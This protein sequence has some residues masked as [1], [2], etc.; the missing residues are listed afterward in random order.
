LRQFG[1]RSAAP[2]PLRLINYRKTNVGAKIMEIRKLIYG[3][4][5]IGVAHIETDE[6]GP[7]G[8]ILTVH[9]ERR[10]RLAEFIDVVTSTTGYTPPDW[11]AFYA[12]FFNSRGWTTDDWDAAA[13]EDINDEAQDIADEIEIQLIDQHPEGFKAF[14]PPECRDMTE[15]F[16]SRLGRKPSPEELRIWHQR[17]LSARRAFAA[18]AIFLEGENRTK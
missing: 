17:Y 11:A 14:C 4:E 5:A 15:S 7:E 10:P 3:L 16:S 2:S 8:D 9:F 1:N 6:I 13:L 12:E 18:A